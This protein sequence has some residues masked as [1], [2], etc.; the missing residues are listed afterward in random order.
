[1]GYATK[2]GPRATKTGRSEAERQRSGSE[3]GAKL[4]L[5]LFGVCSVFLGRKIVAVARQGG[6]IR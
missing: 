3:D 1:M 4:G 6:R 5:R 2:L